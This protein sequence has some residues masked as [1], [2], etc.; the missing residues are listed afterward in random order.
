MKLNVFKAFTTPV[1]PREGE[2]NKEGSSSWEKIQVTLKLGQSRTLPWDKG[3][4]EGGSARIS[5][6]LL[7]GMLILHLT[8]I[9]T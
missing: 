2:I 1:Q 8:H 3:H 4:L 6:T 9:K 5:E 7:C